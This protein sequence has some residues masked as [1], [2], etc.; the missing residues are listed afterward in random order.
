MSREDLL[1][2]HSG[3]AAKVSSLLPEAEELAKFMETY[4]NID[5]VESTD[6]IYIVSGKKHRC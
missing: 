3:S 5:I 2:H 6:E 4:F 1:K